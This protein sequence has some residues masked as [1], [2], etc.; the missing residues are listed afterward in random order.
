MCRA[1]PHDAHVVDISHPELCQSM[2]EAAGELL[3]W[4]GRAYRW[5]DDDLIGRGAYGNVYLATQRHTG[6]KRSL[7]IIETEDNMEWAREFEIISL[8]RHRNIVQLVERRM[9]AE[10]SPGH[11]AGRQGNWNNTGCLG[12]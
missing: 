10:E 4:A 5:W 8:L 2:A 7:H 1:A 12:L 3:A 11:V 6:M 9:L